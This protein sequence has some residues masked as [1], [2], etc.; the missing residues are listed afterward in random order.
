M[1]NWCRTCQTLFFHAQLIQKAI[2]KFT[3][4]NNPPNQT[5]NHVELS[6]RVKAA[7]SAVQSPKLV[8]C[9]VQYVEYVVETI[10]FSM[11]SVWNTWTGMKMIPSN[12]MGARVKRKLGRKEFTT[13]FHASLVSVSSAFKKPTKCGEPSTSKVFRR[14]KK[15]GKTR[16]KLKRNS[17]NKRWSNFRWDNCLHLNDNM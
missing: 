15:S 3:N 6:F 16:R 13:V 14:L 11:Q 12:A 1:K 5:A 8:F 9:F 4:S 10:H 7:T 17:R 2:W